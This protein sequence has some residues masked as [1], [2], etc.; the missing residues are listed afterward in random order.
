MARELF[1][2]KVVVF[3]NAKTT[4]SLNNTKLKGIFLRFLKCYTLSLYR[5]IEPMEATINVRYYPKLAHDGY[6]ICMHLIIH[7]FLTV[8]K[9]RPIVM[10]MYVMVWNCPILLNL[11][12]SILLILD[13]NYQPLRSFIGPFLEKR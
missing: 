1:A 7:L 9:I 6:L 11:F 8:E 10:V 5:H 12:G 4:T 3:S 2:S 13:D